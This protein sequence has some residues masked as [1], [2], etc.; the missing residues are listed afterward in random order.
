L[1]A[2]ISLFSSFVYFVIS[3]TTISLLNKI[4]S[5]VFLLSVYVVGAHACANHNPLLS[6]FTIA[7]KNQTWEVYTRCQ[8]NS[9]EIQ[10]KSKPDGLN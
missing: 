5:Q 7:Q 6:R 2:F 1:G 9:D 4:K 10:R 8:E 3:S